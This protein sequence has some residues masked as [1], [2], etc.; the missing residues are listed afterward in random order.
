MTRII[1]TRH[2][3]TDWNREERFRGRTDVALNE[4]GLLQAE[5]TSR[6]IQSRWQ[7]VAVYTSPMSRAVKTGEIIAAPLGLQAYPL[8]SLNDM[9]YGEWQ[10]LT[11]DEVKLR[12]GD[13]LDTWYRAPHLVQFPGGESLVDVLS[14]TSKALYEITQKHPSE[15]VVVVG[16]DNVNRVMLLYMLSLPLSR[17]WHLVQR[18]CAI[19]FIEFVDNDFVVVSMNE[20]GHLA[21]P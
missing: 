17:Y 3:Q 20:T 7:P 16:H 14:R 8:Q 9:N 18:N 11:A 19:N 5:L 2:G 15:D 10:G 21:T 4:T 13:L 1:L 12:W 6:C